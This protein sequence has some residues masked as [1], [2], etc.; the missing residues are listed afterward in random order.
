[1]GMKLLIR[2]CNS[3]G[4]DDV[5]DESSASRFNKNNGAYRKKCKECGS[6]DTYAYLEEQFDW[7]R[8]LN[9]EKQITINEDGDLPRGQM[10]I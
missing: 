9:E 3:C 5:G 6:T 4:N 8:E 1:M 10:W 2:H 7:Y